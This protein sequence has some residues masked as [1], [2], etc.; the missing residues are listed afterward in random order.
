MNVKSRWAHI[1]EQSAHG[2][3]L[4]ILILDVL[5]EYTKTDEADELREQPIVDG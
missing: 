1:K 3:H 4:S 2:P 5:H